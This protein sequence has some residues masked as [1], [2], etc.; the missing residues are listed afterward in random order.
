MTGSLGPSLSEFVC[1]G[2]FIGMVMSFSCFFTAFCGHLEAVSENLN[3]H[4]KENNVP[5]P[6]QYMQKSDGGICDER[7]CAQGGAGERL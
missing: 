5:L 7:P 2:R 3:K 4:E 6:W 1:I